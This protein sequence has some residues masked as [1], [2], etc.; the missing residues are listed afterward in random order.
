MRKKLIVL[1][2]LAILTYMFSGCS[3]RYL[4]R[5]D[6]RKDVKE[7]IVTRQDPVAEISVSPTSQQIQQKNS[8]EVKITYLREMNPL[9]YDCID[10]SYDPLEPHLLFEFS[11]LN[12]SDEIKY[13]SPVFVF[14][15]H[16]G[17]NLAKEDPCEFFKTYG[18]INYIKA[19]PGNKYSL[20]IQSDSYD[21]SASVKQWSPKEFTL[22]P[23]VPVHGIFRGQGPAG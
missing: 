11:M 2:L 3:G 1:F 16:R 4:K 15:G 22:Y 8:V 19:K 17:L 21:Q 7:E 10:K 14:K 6:I 23:D 9:D 18:K 5:V 13:Y 20:S 12:T